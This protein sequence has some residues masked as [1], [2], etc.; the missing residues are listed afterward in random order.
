M[1]NTNKLKK[2][3]TEFVKGVTF[4]V[5]QKQY[6]KIMTWKKEGYSVAR[7]L[8]MLVDN[9]PNSFESF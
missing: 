4:K 3:Y 2:D 9:A 5:T 6:D 8:R 7:C 1:N